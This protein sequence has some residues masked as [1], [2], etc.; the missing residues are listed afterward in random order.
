MTTGF[1]TTYRWRILLFVA[2]LSMLATLY[3]PVVLELAGIDVAPALYA[4]QG[5]PGGC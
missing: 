4:C 3:S 1:Q 2:L 5:P